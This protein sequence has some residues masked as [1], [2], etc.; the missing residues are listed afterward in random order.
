MIRQLLLKF[1]EQNNRNPTTEEL[2]TLTKG[3][4]F[5]FTEYGKTNDYPLKT[6]RANAK[7]QSVYRNQLF[8]SDWAPLRDSPNGVFDPMAKGSDGVSIRQRMID[9]MNSKRDI[10]MD[11]LLKWFNPNAPGAGM[12]CSNGLTQMLLM[13]LINAR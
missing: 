10:T 9:T 1:K 7:F 13:L 6:S 2:E 4:T 3:K 5:S 11:D 12:T 8:A